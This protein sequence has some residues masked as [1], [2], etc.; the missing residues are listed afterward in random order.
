MWLLGCS[1]VSSVDFLGEDEQRI[2]VEPQ[3]YLFFGR[4][5]CGLFESAAFEYFP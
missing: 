3:S 1:E 2:V 5:S 4:G